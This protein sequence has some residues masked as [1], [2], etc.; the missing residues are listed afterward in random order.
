MISSQFSTLLTTSEIACPAA[1][2]PSTAL[3]L[4][5]LFVFV[6]Y[7]G[8]CFCRVVGSPPPIYSDKINT[9][10]SCHQ[11]YKST[12]STWRKTLS[13]LVSNNDSYG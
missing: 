7:C 5:L 6:Y 8:G 1:T 2:Y 9:I 11:G 10:K 4:L 3:L 12:Q 13:T